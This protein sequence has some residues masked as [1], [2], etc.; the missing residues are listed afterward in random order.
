M[1]NGDRPCRK[2]LSVA[3][4]QP[5]L[6]DLRKLVEP[7]TVGDPMRPLLWMDKNLGKVV[8]HGVYDVAANAGWI[9]VGGVD[10]GKVR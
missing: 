4:R 7:A 2:Q 9:T 8:P 5:R 6:S 3:Q 10:Q 1:A